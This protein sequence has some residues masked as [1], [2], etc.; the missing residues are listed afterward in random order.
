MIG[1]M[2]DNQ[3]VN[4]LQS[5]VI[6]RLACYA[7]KKLYL[8]PITYAYKDGFIYCQSKDGLK[9]ELMRKDPRVCFEVDQI[10]NMRSWRSVIL[11]GEYERL[12]NEKE[13]LHAR[14]ILMDRIEPISTGETVVPRIIQ[15][16][17]EA[18][19]IKIKE[20]TGRFEKPE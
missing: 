10:E 7:D 3:I 12:T 19:R 13:Q 1:K 9:V 18:F 11:W 4:I 15:D 14:K 8:I 6:G 17:P 5:Q 20:Q 16:Y 2:N